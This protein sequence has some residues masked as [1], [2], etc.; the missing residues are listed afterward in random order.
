MRAE[1]HLSWPRK[2]VLLWAE[3]VALF[4]VFPALA[5][6][7]H[8]PRWGIHL[9]LWIVTAY[10][11]FHLSRAKDFSWRGLWKGTGWTAEQKSFAV[12]RFLILAPFLAAFTFYIVPD[13]FLSFPKERPLLWAVVMVLYPLLSALPQEVVFRAFFFE[14]Y[15]PILPKFIAMIAMSALSFGFVHVM[16][17]NWIAPV[18]AAGGGAIF[19]YSYAQHRSLKWAAIEHAVYGCFIFT[20]GLGWYFYGAAGR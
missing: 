4:G 6:L 12:I 5:S 14:R 16:F 15:R 8:L 20:L 10:A 9:S 19:A 17:H 13:R 3:M 2:P 1:R 11:L 18:F 7:E